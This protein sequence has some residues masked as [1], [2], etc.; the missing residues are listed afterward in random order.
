M[1]QSHLWEFA[2]VPVRAS[3][4]EEGNHI[5]LT[6]MRSDRAS[7]QGFLDKLPPTQPLALRTQPDP[8]ANA[9]LVWH[10]GH[11][12]PMAITPPDSNGARKTGAFL[13]FVPEQDANEIRMVEDGFYLFLTDRAWLKIREALLSGTD[14]F[15][16]PAG[17]GGASLS[18]V[19]A[20]PAAYTSP[21]SG[22]TYTG[23]RWT[24][25][26]PETTLPLKE[27]VAV[28][29]SRTV[30]LTSQHELEARSTAEDL[31]AYVNAI[32]NVVDT[33]FTPLGRRISCELTIQFALTV[34]GHEVRFIAADLSADAAE[35]L[36]KRLESV[37]APKVGGPVKLD[38]IIAVWSVA[39]N[40]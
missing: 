23:E 22:E 4:Y 40:Q 25:Y 35:D 5:F 31:A 32:E 20:K 36:H 10:S 17:V 27:L 14:V 26:R 39:S 13:A 19:W 1:E 8:R 21:A 28:S 3:Y 6:L 15:V 18:V 33:F 29:S 7:L 11:N 16:P 24:T 30:L 2:R 12:Q 38:L 37:T 9:C 34:A